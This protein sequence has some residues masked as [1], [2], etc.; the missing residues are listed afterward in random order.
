MPFSQALYNDY[1]ISNIWLVVTCCIIYLINVPFS[2]QQLRDQ[3]NSDHRVR[4]MLDVR[5]ICSF[6]HLII[7]P[8][9]RI[10]R[11]CFYRKLW[12]QKTVSWSCHSNL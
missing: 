12:L 11:L 1:I 7:T 5:F 4:A 8:Q 2:V 6:I 10:V 3:I 9:S